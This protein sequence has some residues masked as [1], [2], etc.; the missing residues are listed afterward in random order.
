MRAAG[1]R[2][3]SLALQDG[4]GSP[5]CPVPRARL[6][7]WLLAALQDD[8]RLT[9]RFVGAREGRA[10]NRVY[11]GR[12]YATNVLTFDYGGAPEGPPVQAD[13][14]IC[15]PVVAREARQQ[16]KPVDHHL[17]HLLMHAALHAQ[18]LSHDDALEA[19]AMESL[20]ATLL[21]RFRIPDPYAREP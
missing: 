4:P 15:M 19:E 20:E 6:R 17:A 12:D 18:G 21:R 16:R 7:R 8:A 5:P 13:I 10:L 3:L 9:V 1:P 14:V 11:R 2:R